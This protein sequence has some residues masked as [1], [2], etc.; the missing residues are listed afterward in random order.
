MKLSIMMKMKIQIPKRKNLKNKID[1]YITKK[2]I[3]DKG[4][5]VNRMRTMS[6]NLIYWN[7]QERYF[8]TLGVEREYCRR[9]QEIYK[10]RFEWYRNKYLT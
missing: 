4:Y 2:I 3:N 9:M 5:R 6:D 1:L 8:S 7:S 10:K